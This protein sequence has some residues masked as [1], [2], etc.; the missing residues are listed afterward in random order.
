MR[1]TGKLCS[2]HAFSNLL[3]IIP[4]LGVSTAE[5]RISI[6]NVNSAPLFLQAFSISFLTSSIWSRAYSF[7]KPLASPLIT[8]SSG[9]TFVAVPPEINPILIVVSPTLP[10]LHLLMASDATLIAWIPE[11]GLNAACAAFPL[12]CASNAI[13]HAAWT[14]AVPI[15]S[16]RSNTYA[17]SDLSLLK[18]NFLIPS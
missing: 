15:L 7:L 11:L 5:K 4:S 3:T 16:V 6:S 1:F 13:I 10:K 12:I 8:H 2:L 14:A 9:T 18:S 17:S